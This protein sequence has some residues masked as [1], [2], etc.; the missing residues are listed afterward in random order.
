MTGIRHALA[1]LV[2]VTGATAAGCGLSLEDVPLPSLVDGPTYPV[3]V[4]FEDALN[5]PLLALGSL[6]VV[7]VVGHVAGSHYRAMLDAVERGDLGEAQRLHRG[8]VPVVD[9]IM[10]P[11]QGAIMAKAAL[12]ELG[13]IEHATVRLPLVESPPEHL[14]ALR[15]A[16]ATLPTLKD[17]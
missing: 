10:S 4:E 5:L 9:A 7:S 6:G 13:V 1:T 2:L 17:A 14:E 3:T 8:L 11:S 12:V 16:L 15:A